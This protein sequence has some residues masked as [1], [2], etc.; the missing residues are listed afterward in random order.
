MKLQASHAE[1]AIS[2]RLDK[3][4]GMSISRPTSRAG[5]C[6]ALKAEMACVVAVSTCAVPSKGRKNSGYR[7]EVSSQP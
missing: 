2:Y 4:D 1:K 7:I 6:I 3:K 5:S